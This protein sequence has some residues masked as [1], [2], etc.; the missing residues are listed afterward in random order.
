[1][2][3]TI[4]CFWFYFN[5]TFCRALFFPIILSYSPSLTTTTWFMVFFSGVHRDFLSS[6]FCLLC[7][8]GIGAYHC[9]SLMALKIKLE[10]R[11][12]SVDHWVFAVHWRFCLKQFALCV[13]DVRKVSETWK[14]QHHTHL[15]MNAMWIFTA[16]RFYCIFNVLFQPLF[17]VYMWYRLFFV[18]TC[19]CVWFWH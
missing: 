18:V 8:F 17:Y 14:H 16:V 15:C 13:S 2:C 3:Q 6:D 5:I 11:L 19:L 7:V 4:R 10:I 1:M 9:N 12:G